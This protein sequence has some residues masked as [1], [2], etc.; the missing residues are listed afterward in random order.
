MAGRRVIGDGRYVLDRHPIGKGGMGE[1]YFGRDTRLERDVA[2]KFIRFPDG[3]PDEELIRRFTRESRMAARLEHPG[4]PAV[5]DVGTDGARP[6]LVMQRM[7]GVTVADLIVEHEPLPI[8]WAAA[9]AAQTC[10]VLSAAHQTSLVHRDLKPGNLMLTPDGTVLVLDFGLAVAMDLPEQSRIT[11]TGQPLGTPAYMAPEQVQDNKSSPRSDLYSLGCTL[12]EMLTGRQVFAGGSN[13]SVMERHL[14]EEPMP[15]GEL[16]ADVPPELDQLVRHLLAKSPAD[17]PPDAEAVFGRLLPFVTDLTELPGMVNPPVLPNHV[18]MYAR[19]LSRV[20]PPK[21]S[22]DSTSVHRAEKQEDASTASPVRKTDVGRA[23]RASEVSDPSGTGGRDTSGAYP[24]SWIETPDLA[25]DTSWG[26]TESDP[27]R[28]ERPTPVVESRENLDDKLAAV[29]ELF[30]SSDYRGAAPGYRELA[31]QFDRVGGRL[32]DA[33]E[34]LR[35]EAVCLGLVGELDAAMHRLT[36]LLVRERA[37]LQPDDPRPLD[38]RRQLGLLQ[39]GA[40]REEAARATFRTLLSDL[41]R[42]HG[43]GH[44]EV[45]RARRLLMPQPDADDTTSRRDS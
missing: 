35:R 23:M 6:Y 8:G 43:A 21:E 20:F 17:R 3:E 7:R 4:V 36:E 9:V 5:Y 27:P 41:V 10:A 12:H 22:S 19:V 16:R 1:V 30:A 39:R 14:R 33:L 38:L 42:I 29:T 24:R 32:D 11:R 18:R 44:P 2:V 25:G 28:P 34:C 15:T 31:E 37:E 45:A 26:S 13:F 40:G